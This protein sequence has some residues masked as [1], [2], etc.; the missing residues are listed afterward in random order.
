MVGIKKR[1]GIKW[2]CLTGDCAN[3]DIEVTQIMI[4][5][6]LKSILLQYN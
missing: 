1:D 4:D 3:I 5:Q 2:K 6:T